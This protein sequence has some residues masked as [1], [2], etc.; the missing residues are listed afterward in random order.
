MTLYLGQGAKWDLVT[1][2]AAL[3]NFTR[4]PVHSDADFKYPD[5]PLYAV[6]AAL[7]ITAGAATGATEFWLGSAHRGNSHN[8]EG[9][10]CSICNDLS[11]YKD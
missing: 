4:Q 9:L 2:N 3:P 8:E 1:G 6:A 11:R 5:C 7:L 10:G